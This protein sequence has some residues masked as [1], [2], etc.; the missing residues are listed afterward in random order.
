MTFLDA[1]TVL[2]VYAEIAALCLVVMFFLWRQN[3]RHSPEIVL[4][5]ID[6]AM[7]FFAFILIILRGIIPDFF[8]IV[9]A[10][11]M[12]ICGS[13]VFY[14]GLEKYVK[15]ESRHLHFFLIA[16]IF[17]LVHAYFTHVYP[18]FALRNVNL[19]AAL[20]YI[21]G[22][23]SFLMLR[24]TD[25]D[26][27]GSARATGIVLAVFCIL[28]ISHIIAYLLLRENQELF[29]S[30]LYYAV[31][32][33]EYQLLFILLTFAIML[34]VGRRLLTKLEVE[35]AERVEAEEELKNSRQQ[36]QSLIETLN[37]FI[38]E[39]DSEG[40]YTYVSPQIKNILGY[41]PE[42][43]LGKSP[44]DLMDE[45]EAKRVLSIFGALA[46]DKNPIFGL[47][48]VN[49]H[50]DGY[51]VVL[52]TN[53]MP[54]IDDDGNLKGYRG[55][56]RD[57]TDRKRAEV[58][59]QKQQR[60]LSDLIEHSG[61]MVCVKDRE[62]LY[63]LVNRMWE[64]KTGL[65][66]MDVIG[67]TDEELFPGE[68]G[69]QFRL[70]DLDV[71]ESG[72]VIEREETL[73][74]GQGRK[75]LL[76]IKFPLRGDN[77]KIEG[78][79]GMFNDITERK[80]TEEKIKH[81]ATHDVLTDLPSLRLAGDRLSMAM[82]NA[83]RYKNK[84]AVMFLDLD[85]FKNVNDSFGHDAGDYVLKQVALRLLNC[86]RTTDTVAR[87][88]GDEFLLIVTE[89]HSSDDAARIAE[90]IIN[91]ISRPITFN[92]R[93]I[94]VGAS[95][96]VAI[97]PDHGEDMDQLI[98]NADEAMYRVKNSGKNSFCFAGNLI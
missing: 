25:P 43:I 60:F 45:D 49:Q 68:S 44:A 32:L 75:I 55:T 81:L 50:K 42:E 47:E 58:E 57:I 3:R 18:S 96:G 12:M 8:S 51:P 66:R 83:R 69:R 59:L 28:S 21:C 64:K 56:D 10:N 72:H 85:G 46:K 79:C 40:N 11:S 26:M 27:R 19:S 53:G 22:H 73:V 37:D 76:S 29:K 82:S 63:T 48:N 9:A 6:Y 86:V 13:I 16:A 5:L 62:G 80:E 88:G 71:L 91:S 52:E 36:F 7:Q 92:D 30:S 70:N 34:M 74:D 97:F 54:F 20:L 15:K 67:K 39:V 2:I 1:K 24:R 89:I 87:V 23:G 95:L 31:T 35:L 17:T 61:A 38:W 84:T 14:I 4:W 77:G 93:Y 78:L 90:N 41:E 94:I 65:K 98:K 33:L